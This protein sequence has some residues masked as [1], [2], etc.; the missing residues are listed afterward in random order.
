MSM[1]VCDLKVPATFAVSTDGLVLVLTPLRCGVVNRGKY[2]ESVAVC[3]M[4]FL[5]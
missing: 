1:A 4:S 5:L 2:G 3:E